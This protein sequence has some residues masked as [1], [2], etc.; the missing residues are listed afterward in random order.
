MGVRYKLYPCWIIPLHWIVKIFLVRFMY[1]LLSWRISYIRLCWILLLILSKRLRLI[2]IPRLCLRLV[3]LHKSIIMWLG[4]ISYL[5]RQ[6]SPLSTHYPLCMKTLSFSTMILAHFT[7]SHPSWD[8]TNR[9]KSFILEL[10]N[11]L[12]KIH[13]SRWKSNLSLGMNWHLKYQAITRE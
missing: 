12:K 13:S 2:L 1:R 8:M 3:Y 9:M 7:K 6:K 10:E 11:S 5:Y 4:S